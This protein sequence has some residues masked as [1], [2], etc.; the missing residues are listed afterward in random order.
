MKNR[1][2][3]LL[4]L[5][6]VFI[7]AAA[8]GVADTPETLLI[9]QALNND[10]FGIRRGIEHL[11][12]ALSAVAKDFVAY[13]GNNTLDPRGWQILHEDRD[14]YAAAL[15]AD[16]T[17]HQYDIE[18]AVPHILV[19]E[20]KAVATTLDSGYVVDRQ[21]GERRFVK[22]ERFWTF[23]KFD[24]EWLATSFVDDM[25]DAT[26]GPRHDSIEDADLLEVLKEDGDNWKSGSTG[27]IVGMLHEDFTGFNGVAA[28]TP[29]SWTILFP[30]S[31][32]FEK[33]LAKRMERTVYEIERE[34]LY[35]TVGPNGKEA[36]A[37]T[38]DH[39]T[40]NYD[41]G[42]VVHNLDR[43]VLWTFSRRSGRWQVTNALF[44]LGL[45][46]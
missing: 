33:W 45:T 20:K 43:Y 32:V 41:A 4:A 18:R 14:A 28:V 38:L 36:L 24:E 6:L 1:Q 40:T 9:R 30:D 16:L 26:A 27:S 37:L 22:S 23:M 5:L 34:V 19:L 29:A 15:S 7:A 35:T 21:S 44:D 42:P 25:G 13:T 39:V 46:D 31:A 3:L 2:S 11:D 10:K 12:V 8:H 17:A